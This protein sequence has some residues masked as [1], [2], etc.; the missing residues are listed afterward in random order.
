MSIVVVD[1]INPENPKRGR[2]LGT[3]ESAEYDM[4]TLIFETLEKGQSTFIE[5]L[6]E[7]LV[8]IRLKRLCDQEYKN[9]QK[10]KDLSELWKLTF[11]RYLE[12]EY[13]FRAEGIGFRVF[14][15]N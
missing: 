2:K 4:G 14:R 8:S 15:I 13:A 1:N 9:V 11:N 7:K 6:R 3:G 10:N 5:G 12:R